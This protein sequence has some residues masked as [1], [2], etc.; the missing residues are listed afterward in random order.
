M[1]RLIT[2]HIVKTEKPEIVFN[3]WL[4]RKTK[5]MELFFLIR[6]RKEKEKVKISILIVLKVS[7]KIACQNNDKARE[8]VRER[9]NRHPGADMIVMGTFQILRKGKKSIFFFDGN[10]F[11]FPSEDWIIYKLQTLLDRS[12][13]FLRKGMENECLWL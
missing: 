3:F 4:G 6:K 5:N 11:F 10:L 2:L 7:W 8:K 13:W 1:S 9:V 12:V